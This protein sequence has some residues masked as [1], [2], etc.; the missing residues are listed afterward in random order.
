[1]R[2]SKLIIPILFITTLLLVSKCANAYYVQR[3]DGSWSDNQD[4]TNLSN[5]PYQTLQ[6]H[7][8]FNE[9]EAQY[10]INNY[11]NVSS[12]TNDFVFRCLGY[13]Y[14]VG[15]ERD[16][17]VTDFPS[18]VA[19]SYCP[20]GY[21]IDVTFASLG[22]TEQVSLFE[23]SIFQNI[24][25]SSGGTDT[26]PP[27]ITLIGSSS[28]QHIEGETYIDQGATAN[29]D[30]DGDITGSILV[31]NNVDQ[32][33]SGTYFVTYDVTDAA[34]NPA[35]QVTRT[36]NVYVPTDDPPVI[37]LIGSAQMSLNVDDTYI[38]QG[39]TATDTEDGDLTSN[40][41]ITG[42]VNTAVDGS[43]SIVYSVIDSGGNTSTV[44][45]TVNVAAVD[46]T[47]T[48]VLDLE[49]YVVT[50]GMVFSTIIGFGHGLRFRIF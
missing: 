21:V 1:M 17:P 31:V 8:N 27:V 49:E 32:N 33:N 13:N 36:V 34:G 29:D 14:Q 38:E 11:M 37:T 16:R 12:L 7:L 35:T 5:E 42:T 39:A 50:L 48:N 22:L 43:Y 30:T 40:I 47:S 18:F 20:A 15:G 45:R 41:T 4:I 19:N 10:L 28:I 3:S 2:I 46:T 25:G 24:W 6:L 44:T 23:G 9:T 26:T